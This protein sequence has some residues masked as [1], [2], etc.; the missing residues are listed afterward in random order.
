MTLNEENK[1]TP[2]LRCSFC[3]KHQGEVFQLIAGPE[4]IF[5][6]DNCVEI[7]CDVISKRWNVFKDEIAKAR[8][9]PKPKEQTP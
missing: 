2:V 7:C 6:C 4:N 1:T 8:E 3:G 5:I 9:E